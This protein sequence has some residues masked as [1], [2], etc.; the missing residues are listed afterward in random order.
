MIWIDS[1][2]KDHAIQKILNHFQSVHTKYFVS[3]LPV[4]DYMSLDNP[5]LVIDRKQNL[6]ELCQNVCQDHKRFRSELERANEYGIKLIILCEHGGAVKELKDVIHWINPRLRLSPMAMSGE[7]LYKV[8]S[9]MGEKYGVRFEFCKKADTGEVYVL[10]FSRESVRFA[11]QGD[12][13]SQNYLIFPRPIF[14]ICFS[15]LSA[16]TIKT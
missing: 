9:A 7:R 8:L 6:S 2:E 5:R 11:E 4:G 16:K 12:L 10:E 14:L 13:K 15:M 3:K 1:R